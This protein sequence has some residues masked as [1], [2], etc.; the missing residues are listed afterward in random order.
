MIVIPAPA[1]IQLM[2]VIPAPAEIQLM[3]VIPTRAGIQAAAEPRDTRI[4][5]VRQDG[6]DTR[7][8]F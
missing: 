1:G 4:P 8:R 5:R 6:D 2:I 7:G 3:V